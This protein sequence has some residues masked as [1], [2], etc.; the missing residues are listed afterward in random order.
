MPP[1][2]RYYNPVD[3]LRSGRAGRMLET[4]SHNGNYDAAKMTAKSGHL[5]ALC[6]GGGFVPTIAVCVD[7][8]EQWDDFWER[9]VDGKFIDFI[10]YVLTDEEHSRAQ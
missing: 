6:D 2:R 8:R 10:V 5:Y 1:R 4:L 7:E 3:D 9:Y